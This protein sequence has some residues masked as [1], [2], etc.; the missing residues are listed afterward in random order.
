[1]TSRAQSS[2]RY[3]FESF[4]VDLSSGEVWK[5]G[6]RVRLQDQPFQVLRVLLE[7][8]G[9]IVTREELKQTLWPGDTF[10]DFDDGLN[11][12]VKKIRDL[13]GD[14]A[15]RPRYIETIP[16]R[17]Y[18]FV[19]PIALP[20]STE[21]S[22]PAPDSQPTSRVPRA[23]RA[24]R[25]RTSRATR[26][27]AV[28]LVLVVL[29]AGADVGGW[30]AHLFG[31]PA[32]PRI[33]SLAVLPLK[34]LSGD[35][36]QEYLADGMTLQLITTLTKISNLTVIS[37]TS[38]RGLK[39]TTKTLPEIAKQL[40]VDGVIDGSV[41]RSGDRVK[42]TIQLIHPPSGRNLWAEGYDRQLRDILSFQEE[43]AGTIARE[44]R[45]ALTPQDRLRLSGARPVDPQAYL[46]YTQGRSLMQRWTPDTWQKARESFHQAIEKDP[47]YASAYAGL[48]ETYITGDNLDPKISIPL[49]RAAASRALALDDTAGDAHVANAQVKYMED[50]DFNGAEKE[51]KRAI[52]LN[53]GDMLAHH[54]YS[55]LLLAMGRNQE[56]LKE[57]ELYVRLDPV[58][59]A[60]YDHLGFQYLT[61]GRYEQAIVEYRKLPLLD[62]SWESSHW[63]LGDSYRYQGMPQEALAEYERAMAL[64]GTRAEVVKAL[65]RAFE[66][67]GW[68]AYWAKSLS[69]LLKKSSHEYVSP[70]LIA[71]LYAQSGDKENAFRCLEKAYATHD[72]SLTFIKADRDL[73][74][75]H[76]DPRYASLLQKMGLSV[77]SQDVF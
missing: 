22:V 15:E 47:D 32:I 74:L 55:H 61:D 60:A 67:G 3:R 73:D 41:E 65:R 30:R 12:A 44:V 24:A 35:P 20:S 13:L 51:F 54:L 37:W 38:V 17:G 21:A 18:R 26:Y 52:E 27:A 25:W 19:A 75:L 63:P 8:P 57:S 33:E 56:S 2:N 31:H 43:V 70:Y 5:H 11:T 1:M 50:W 40:N 59:P 71:T 14:S 23:E 62:P 49:A 72:D 64:D 76:S 53:P 9:E 46:L 36:A 39:N 7:R 77:S 6:T 66:S 28:G 16:R 45:I 69:G 48:A 4:E 34:N 42:I 68:K 58:S 29:L 10:V